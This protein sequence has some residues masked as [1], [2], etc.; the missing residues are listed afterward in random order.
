[1]IFNSLAE[2]HVLFQP[3]GEE[4]VP[5]TEEDTQDPSVPPVVAPAI[6]IETV[7][8]PLTTIANKFKVPLFQ[9]ENF[10]S[11]PVATSPS[12]RLIEIRDLCYSKDFD[13]FDNLL[14]IQNQFLTYYKPTSSIHSFAS[15]NF[16][17]E[18]LKAPPITLDILRYGYS[19]GVNDFIFIFHLY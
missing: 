15:I 12:F 9:T 13:E 11:I 18:V 7:Q 19:P 17:S 10:D 5:L 8:T 6:R 2:D 16:Y 14:N 4:E 3:E 1:M